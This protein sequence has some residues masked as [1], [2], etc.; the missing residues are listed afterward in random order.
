MRCIQRGGA[1]SRGS[2]AISGRRRLQP[3]QL[4]SAP[5]SAPLEGGSD[6]LPC[7]TQTHV[8]LLNCWR[9]GSHHPCRGPQARRKGA[10]NGHPESM[11]TACNLAG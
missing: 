6:P 4:Q 2:L 5:T 7:V 9:S 11:R 8:G 3:T 1:K 10:A